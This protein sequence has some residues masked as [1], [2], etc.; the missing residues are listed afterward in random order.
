MNIDN[1]CMS[2]MNELYGEKQC[3]KCGYYVDSPQ[4][5]PYLPLKTLVGDKYVIGKVLSSNSEGATYMAYDTGRN[6][7][8]LIREFLPERFVDRSFGTTE[9]SVKIQWRDYYY[10]YLAKFLELWRRLARVR[11]LSALVPVVDIVEEN[12]TAYVVTEYVE[13]ISLRE[14]LL[15]SQTGYLNWEK[16]KVLFMPVLSTISALHQLGI[17]HN[18]INPDNLFIGRDGKLR[19]SGFSIS[20]ARIEGSELS[21][22]FFEGYTSIEQ[23]GYNYENGCWSDVYAFCAVIYRALVG[24]VPQDAVSRSMNDQLII[25]ARYAEIIPVYVIN[26]LMNGLQV[27]PQDRTPDIETL[28]EEL[29]ATPGNVASSFSGV[30]VPMGERKPPKP[31]PVVVPEEESSTG[32][33]ILITFLVCLGIGLIIF[34]GWFLYDKMIKEQPEEPT[35]TTTQAH[36]MYE[37]PNFVNSSY[38]MVGQ[39]PV[40]NQRF[41]IKVEMKY[42]TEVEKGYIIS[43]SIEPGQM[44]AAGTEIIFEVSKGPEYKI[45]PSVKNLN[46]DF[47]KEQLEE[48]GFVVNIIIKENNGD[49]EEGDVAEVTPEEGS[50]RIKGSEVYIQVYGPPPITEPITEPVTEDEPTNNGILSGLFG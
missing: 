4:I 27:D 39:N 35:E 31:E 45:I 12:N 43:Q 7:S 22:E 28:R 6:I 19:L 3:P 25:P 42:S 49:Y 21:P 16:A 46:V 26:A 40:Q 24:S 29:S 14:F 8:V 48:A 32:K 37:V 18:G 10:N 20:E 23:Y 47:A 17:T 41:T 9:I 11:G 34:G 5:S 30:S 15:R 33:I 13:S 50:S 2:C 44:V 36:E 1:L 38:D